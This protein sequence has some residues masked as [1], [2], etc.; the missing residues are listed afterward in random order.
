MIGVTALPAIDEALALVLARVQPLA[1]EDGARRARGRPRARARTRARVRRPAAVRQLGDGRLR[2][3]RGGHARPLPRRRA[4]GRRAR[5]SARPLAA[6]EAVV[7]STGAVVPEGADAVVPVERTRARRRRRAVE[8]VGPGAHVRPRGGDARSGEVDRAPRAQLLGPT[9]VGALAAVGLD[10]G[11]VR[12]A[13]RASRCSR[14]AASCARPARRSRRARSTSRTP[15]CS[16]RSSSRRAREPRRARAGRRRR[17]RDARRARA[18][19]RG[20]RADHLRR[21]LGRAARSRARR[22]CRSSARTRC[23]GAS[24]SSPGKPIAF[25]TRGA[26]LVFGL[27]GNPVSSLVGFEL[28]VR[29][30]LL[31]L[32]GAREPRPAFLP[33][34]LG[35]STAAERRAGRARSR[36]RARRAGRRRARAADAVRSR[37]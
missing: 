33:G 31:A 28:F 19:A 15:R 9:Q 5:R 13:A 8:A 36:T 26:T 21:R 37:T 18:R 14:P 25:A 27:P 24:P 23:S 22:A 20:R 12:A 2:R 30:A 7:I 16:R 34:R 1:A 32:Q 6:G 29:P 11:R 17:G 3:A 10:D 35:A 4:V